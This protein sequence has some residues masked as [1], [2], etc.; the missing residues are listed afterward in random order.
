MRFA[1]SHLRWRSSCGALAS[2]FLVSQVSLMTGGLRFVNRTLRGLG[3][4]SQN[5]FNSNLCTAKNYSHFDKLTCYSNFMQVNLSSCQ[6]ICPYDKA[7]SNMGYPETIFCMHTEMLLMYGNTQRTDLFISGQPQ[8]ALCWK[9]DW[10]KSK[11][12]GQLF[13]QC[14]R[15]KDT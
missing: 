1:Q 5:D 11:E 3:V 14:E 6:W 12:S 4:A 15:G 13:T 10:S 9:S 8:M 2:S 7:P